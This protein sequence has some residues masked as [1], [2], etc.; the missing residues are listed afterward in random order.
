MSRSRL[1]SLLSVLAVALG[2]LSTVSP[3]GAA[4]RPSAP[5]VSGQSVTGGSVTVSLDWDFAGP[6]TYEVLVSAAGPD[7]YPG[8]DAYARVEPAGT[9]HADI[10]GL[11]PGTTYCF[12]VTLEGNGGERTCK[13]TPPAT[14]AVTPTALATTAATFNLACGSKSKCNSGWKWKKRQKRVVDSIGLMNAD[15]MV[16]AEAHL[17]HKYGKKKRWIGKVMKKR[18]YTLACQ[19]QKSRKRKLYSQVAYVRSSVYAVV[20]KRHNSKGS[21]F[22]RFG[23]RD[24]G[25]CHALVQHR[26][27]GKL[28]AL[29]ALHL[30]DGNADGVRQQE[31]AYVLGRIQARF[32]GHQTVLLGD[33]NSHRGHERR[34]QVDAPR[35]V[36]EA[37]G[38]ADASDIAARLTYPYLNS[39]HGFDTNPPRSTT[40][41]THVDRIFVSPG[42]TVPTWE[43]IA[44]LDG[45]GHYATPMASDHNPIKATL[46]I[47]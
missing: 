30:R 13:V 29:G 2:V 19:T 12:A 20:D 10:A 43:N 41:P 47:P 37:A 33:F 38:F 26:A 35:L 1:L 39:A 15:V 14:R 45:S 21:R 40:W 6:G 17:A 25:Y 5:W 42:I 7:V 28:V 27:T 36:L 31:T 44:V 8:D 46:H 34:G 18:G 16:F 24:H 32:A 23:D 11:T 3:A 4:G 9:T 22:T